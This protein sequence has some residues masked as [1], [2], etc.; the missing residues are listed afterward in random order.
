MSKYPNPIL[1]DF[2]NDIAFSVVVTSLKKETVNN[3]P[4]VVTRVN[5]KITAEYGNY[6]ETFMSDCDFLISEDQTE[7]TEF[8]QLTEEQVKQWCMDDEDLDQMKASLATK[9]SSKIIDQ[10][11]KLLTTTDFPWQSS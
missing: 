8:S 4:D 5:Y 10:Q 7:F 9:I 6:I 2:Y 11:T 3:N 1:P